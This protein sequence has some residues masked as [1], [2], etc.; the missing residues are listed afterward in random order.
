M[1]F[2]RSPA[3]CSWNPTVKEVGAVTLASLRTFREVL[4]VRGEE[5]ACTKG[6]CWSWTPLIG[7][8]VEW[9]VGGDVRAEFPWLA[10]AAVAIAKEL[11]RSRK[12]MPSAPR[13]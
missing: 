3:F 13:T 4:V 12:V 8:A 11:E 6:E 5:V 10:T 2:A 1:M 9:T 7:T